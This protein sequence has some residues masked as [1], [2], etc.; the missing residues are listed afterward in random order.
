MNFTEIFTIENAVIVTLIGILILFI[1]HLI[2][3]KI[4]RSLCMRKNDGMQM[5]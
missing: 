3:T 2:E 4:G 1:I 5:D